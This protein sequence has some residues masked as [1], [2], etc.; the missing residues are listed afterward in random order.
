LLNGARV[1][2]VRRSDE[3]SSGHLAKALNI[4][5]EQLESVLPERVPDRNHT[6]LLRCLSGSRS[7]MAKWKWKRLGYT[8][9]FNLGSF[10]RA[11][12]IVGD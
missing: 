5:M 7:G 10:A 6:L 4:P 9:V 8:N 11:R 2:D 1:I 3:F 12:K